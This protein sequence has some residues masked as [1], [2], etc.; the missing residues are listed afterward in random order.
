MASVEWFVRCGGWRRR[1]QFIDKHLGQGASR[2]G[3]KGSWAD[4]TGPAGPGPFWAGSGPYSS[5]VASCMIPYFCALACG[6]LTSFPSRLRLES[7]LCKLHCFS[8]WVPKDLHVDASVLG[9]FGVMF[10]VCL[11]SCRASWSYSKVLGE[12]IPKVSSLA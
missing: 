6:P 11:D 4:P 5:P 1:R 2:T 12:L 7:L 9:S 10:I 3:P 8:G